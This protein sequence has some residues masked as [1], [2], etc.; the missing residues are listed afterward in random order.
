M[1]W[2][3]RDAR[4][5]LVYNALPDVDHS[6]YHESVSDEYLEAMTKH[7]HPEDIIKFLDIRIAEFEKKSNYYNAANKEENTIRLN[8]VAFLRKKIDSYIIRNDVKKLKR[9]TRPFELEKRE[10]VAS[11]KPKEEGETIE[12][13][14][15]KRPRVSNFK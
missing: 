10:S 13:A 11:I 5:W 3:H 4:Y 15:K 14:E 6:T 12:E 7:N 8:E 2:I 9:H 1:E